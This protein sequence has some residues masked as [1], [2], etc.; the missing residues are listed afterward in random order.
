MLVAVAARLLNEDHLIDAALL[1]AAQELP[2]LVRGAD[3][4][5]QALAAVGRHLGAEALLFQ[6]HR[7]LRVVA[8]L[9]ALLLKLLPNVGLARHMVAEDV[10]V[11]QREAEEVAPLHAAADGLLLVRMHHHRRHAGDFRVH[12]LADGHAFLGQG[13]PV[14]A[15][16]MLGLLRVDEGEGQRP[17]ALLRRQQDGVA[18][19]AGHPQG[20]MRLLHGLGHHVARRHAAVLAVVAGERGLGHAADRHL[21]PLLPH[22]PLQRRVDFEAAQFSGGG[23]LPGAE[24]HPALGDQI[25]GGHPLGGAG[26]MVVSGRR[27]NDAVAEADVLGALADGGQEHLRGAGV[28][29]LLKKVVFHLPDVLDAELVGQFALLQGVLEQRQFRLA[30]PRPGQLMFVKYAESHGGCPLRHLENSA[31]STLPSR[32]RPWRWPPPPARWA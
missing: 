10:E 1:V 25:Q 9:L 20:R 28:G 30:G 29:V 5:A 16:P 7:H 2:Q 14:V 8:H 13:A 15:H 6:G 3:G 17:D 4:A 21:E 26:R 12:R 11:G 24:L 27:L 22:F 19:G 18:A 32:L 23:G 31:Q